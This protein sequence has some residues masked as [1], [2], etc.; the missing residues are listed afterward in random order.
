MDVERRCFDAPWTAGQFRH[1]L[2]VPFSRTILAW[3]DS[4][5]PSRIAGYVCRWAIRDE[6]SILN[7]AVDPDFRRHG[8]GRSLV[9]TV[10]DEAIAAGASSV[11]LEVREK[12]DAAR[13]LYAAMGFT[14]TGLRKNYYAKSDHAIIMTKMLP[15]AAVSEEPLGPTSTEEYT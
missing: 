13:S 4:V 12:N 14:Q 5:Q 7:L 9:T 10:L 8:L 15:R 1:E 11:T 2:K 6:F 3:D